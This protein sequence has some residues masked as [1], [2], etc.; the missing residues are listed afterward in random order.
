IAL[1]DFEYMDRA[2]RLG[3]VAVAWST[4]AHF[5]PFHD[6]AST[7]WPSHLAAALERAAGSTDS[8]ALLRTLQSLTVPLRD[9]HATIRSERLPR[10]GILPL[11]MRRF[12]NEIVTVGVLAPYADLLPVGSRINKLNGVDALSLYE[13]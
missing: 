4:L 13:E 11:M 7:N 5:Y 9:N 10:S 8:A 6:V 12:G 2:S 3:A 1:G